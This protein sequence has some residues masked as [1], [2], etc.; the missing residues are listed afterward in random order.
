MASIPIIGIIGG[1]GSGKSTVAAAFGNAGCA[2]IDADVIAHELLDR[3][4]V[5]GRLIDILGA[6]ILNSN[7]IIDR[8]VLGQV[9]FAQKETLKFLTDILHP[10]VLDRTKA[11]IQQYRSGSQ[12]Y[13]AII[14]DM[15]LLV[16]VEWDKRCDYIVFVE[17]DE[18]HRHSRIEKSGKFNPQQIK[19][20]ENFQISLDK[21]KQ[22]AHYRVNNNSDK[23]D[24]AEQ[25]AQILTT[26]KGSI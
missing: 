7:G 15:P 14:L 12:D 13:P 19:N 26:I 6:G 24:S 17:C 21:K 4:D 10:M 9:V 3:E 8:A 16:E 25:V 23:S 18:A 5:R 22:I 1:I 20:R 2:V 11:Q